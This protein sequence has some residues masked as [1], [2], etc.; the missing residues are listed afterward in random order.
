MTSKRYSESLSSDIVK[1]LT[2][3]AEFR[4]IEAGEHVSRIGLYAELI[5]R[6]LGM[7]NDF[8]STIKLASPLHDIGKIGIIDSILLKPGTLTPEEFEVIKTHTTS[9]ERIL[10]GS[11]H[12][13]LQ[14]ASSIAVC[15]HEKWDGSGYPRGLKGKNIPLEGRIVALSDHYDA[16]RSRRTYK[17]SYSHEDA[18]RIITEGDQR[19]MPD[20]FDPDVLSVFFRNSREFLSIYNSYPSGRM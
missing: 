8:V 9:G 5:A 6:R 16:I 18:V 12:P 10:S 14:M 2:A 13:V 15:H 3:V 7:P 17:P 11:S 19:T 4:D 1:R 20:H